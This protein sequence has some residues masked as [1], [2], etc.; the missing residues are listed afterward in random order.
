MAGR[1]RFDKKVVRAWT[2]QVKLQFVSQFILFVT[3]WTNKCDKPPAQR[4]L[5]LWIHDTPRY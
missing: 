4:Y 5:P 2:A 3:T 1:E